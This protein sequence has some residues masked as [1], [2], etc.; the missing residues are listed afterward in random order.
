MTE[1]LLILHLIIGMLALRA[2]DLLNAVILLAV[3]SLL[4]ALLFFHLHAPDVA[5]TEAAVGAGVSTFVFVWV[6][7]KTSR[8][9]DS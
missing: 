1:I 9:D 8:N 6:I 5:L 7:H 2:K 3:V 4:S